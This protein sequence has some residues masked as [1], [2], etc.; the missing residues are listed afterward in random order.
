MVR[1]QLFQYILS[2]DDPVAGNFGV[3]FWADVVI[4][5]HINVE[6]R[7]AHLGHA[8]SLQCTKDTPELG[9]KTEQNTPYEV[10]S[11]HRVSRPR[12]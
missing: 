2:I 6:K 9:R 5:F 12:V 7:D 8:W 10:V 3:G 1:A 11:A 4:I